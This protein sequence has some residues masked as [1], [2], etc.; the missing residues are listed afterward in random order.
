MSCNCRN[1]EKALS[2]FH[3]SLPYGNPANVSDILNNQEKNP[4]YQG[5]L[6]TAYENDL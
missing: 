3:R 4:G 5:F 1:R 2:E 6:V